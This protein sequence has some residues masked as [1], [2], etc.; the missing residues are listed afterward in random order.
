MASDSDVSYTVFSDYQKIFF[1]RD[2]GS[3]ILKP[4]VKMETFWKPKK[5][6]GPLVP[7]LV[8]VECFHGA[9]FTLSLL[10]SHVVHTDLIVF[11]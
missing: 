6:P 7:K 3:I 8:C 9:K 4:L 10:I 2:A 1:E 5:N 11:D